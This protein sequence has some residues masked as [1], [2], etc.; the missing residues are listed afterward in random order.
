[1]GRARTLVPVFLVLG[2][3]YAQYEVEEA[4]LCEG[5]VLAISAVSGFLEDEQDLG[6]EYRQYARIIIGLIFVV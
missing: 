5:W 3:D 4:C 6:G 1:M 2:Y